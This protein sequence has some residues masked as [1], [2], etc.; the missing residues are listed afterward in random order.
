MRYQSSKWTAARGFT[1]IETLVVAAVLLVAVAAAM[2]AWSHFSRRAVREEL[3]V[4]FNRES[5]SLVS[6]LKK[7]IR[8]S[9][10]AAILDGGLA[11]E[12]NA[13]DSTGVPVPT[14][15]TYR[16]EGNCLVRSSGGEK[17]D[18]IDFASAVSAGFTID[19]KLEPVSSSALHLGIRV[20]TESGK[21]I[22]EREE[23]LSPDRINDEP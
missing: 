17:R 20:K 16:R 8:S 1:F 11:L 18:M 7:D 12:V 2:F 19:F 23:Q 13:I 15:V 3:Q 4:R 9:S 6:H 5:D 21:T 10:S 14:T 22:F